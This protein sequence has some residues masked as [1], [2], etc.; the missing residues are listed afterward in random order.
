MISE[1]IQQQNKSENV[2]GRER[3]PSN[4][5]GQVSNCFR[6]KERKRKILRVGYTRQISHKGTDLGT[7]L[8]K[9][10]L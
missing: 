1:K 2:E 5:T 9:G 4:N 6:G 3:E 8:E 10:K 7:C